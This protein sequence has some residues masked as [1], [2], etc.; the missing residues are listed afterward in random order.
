MRSEVENCRSP[1]PLWLKN[2]WFAVVVAEKQ[3]DM[4]RYGGSY[5]EHRLLITIN[6]L[7]IDTFSIEKSILEY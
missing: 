6:I 7:Q 3:P 4:I 1:H 5:P 2:F